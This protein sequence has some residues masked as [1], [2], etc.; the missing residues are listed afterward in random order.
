[1][2]SDDGN[3]IC[4][5]LPANT[6]S[7]IQPMDQGVIESMKRRYRKKFLQQLLHKDED[8]DL[9]S[10][11]KK[12]NLLDVVNNV[13]DAWDEMQP[14]TL[15]RAWNKWWPETSEIAEDEDENLTSTILELTSTVFNVEEDEANNWL[16]C[17][18][19]DAGYKLLTDD[20]IVEE[21]LEGESV[22]EHDDYDGA[23]S[24][25]IES[26]VSATDLRLEAKEASANMQKF[27]DW[28]QKQD[29]SEMI[30]TM[31]LRKLRAL[32]ENKS[33]V[34]LLQTKVSDFFQKK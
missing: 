27:I 6:T 4:R 21:F 15:S 29:E 12:Y 18:S 2:K 31:F 30:H 10:F 19:E 11:W 22:D 33:D 34:A 9:L 17:D 25:S 5:Y 24:V 20:E 7:I 1:M 26:T 8:S 13:A 14:T 23:D 16:N 32:A 28:Y 3:I